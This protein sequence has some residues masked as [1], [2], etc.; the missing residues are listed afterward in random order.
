MKGAR[1]DEAIVEKE[2][3]KGE[4]ERPR[5]IAGLDGVYSLKRLAEATP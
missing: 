5:P 3:R 2:E 4:E 1:I